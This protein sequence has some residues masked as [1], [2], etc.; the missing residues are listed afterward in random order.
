MDSD[1]F[2]CSSCNFYFEKLY[3][4]DWEIYFY[5]SSAR[6]MFGLSIKEIKKKKFINFA[7]DEING[8]FYRN[9]IVI[10]EP[11]YIIIGNEEILL[12]LKKTEDEKKEEKTFAGISSLSLKKNSIIEEKKDYFYGMK[13]QQSCYQNLNENSFIYLNISSHLKQF[14]VKASK[15]DFKTTLFKEREDIKGNFFIKKD[16]LL[17]V[18]KG[19]DLLVYQFSNSKE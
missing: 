9:Q 10:F 5:N 19:K 2:E 8:F 13:I 14:N 3:F 1:V 11:S 4:K 7:P 17:F 16:D 6:T 12:D 18:L 15:S